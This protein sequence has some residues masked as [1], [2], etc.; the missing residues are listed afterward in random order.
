MQPL[1]FI[2]TFLYST[3]FLFSGQHHLPHS[4]TLHFFNAIPSEWVFLKMIGSVLRSTTHVGAMVCPFSFCRTW[5]V[6]KRLFLCLPIFLN[7][8]RLPRHRWS[9]L[10]QYFFPH[11][12]LSPLFRHFSAQFHSTPRNLSS[13]WSHTWTPMFF[14]PPLNF[15]SGS[16]FSSF[17]SSYPM[18]SKCTHSRRAEHDL[19][20]LTQGSGFFCIFPPHLLVFYLPFWNPFPLPP[21]LHS[22][23]HSPSWVFLFFSQFFLA[24]ADYTGC[25]AIKLD[26]WFCQKPQRCL[27]TSFTLHPIS[28]PLFFL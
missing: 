13:Y 8:T 5:L 6:I 3:F 10:Y 12:F 22:S 16:L 17:L 21:L 25:R 9:C 1:V 18:I 14:F 7:Y 27:L 15:P 2:S 20:D 26:V 11:K 28:N 4:C 24:K 19:R 23:S